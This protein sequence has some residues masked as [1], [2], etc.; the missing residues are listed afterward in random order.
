MP[1]TSYESPFMVQRFLF[2]IAASLLLVVVTGC[3]ENGAAGDANAKRP[4]KIIATTGMVADLVK[5]VVGDCGEVVSLMGPGV[6]PHLFKPLLQH[7]RKM[8]DADVIFYSGLMLEGRMQD[9][10]AQANTP[11]RPAIAVTQK[12]EQLDKDFLRS[13]PEFQGHYDPHV[14]MDVK[15]WARCMDQIV[16][17]LS[18]VDPKNA[19]TFRENA[20]NY[21][22]ELTTLDDYVRK[23]IESIPRP[24]RVLVT[25]HDAFGYFGRAYGIDVRSVQGV[26]TESEAGVRDINRLVEF[27]VQSKIPSIFVESSVSEKNLRAVIEGAKS[28]GVEIKV[29][30][31]L[32]SDAM[33]EEGTYEGTYI[34]MIDHNA[35]KIARA[36][37]GEAPERGLHG[38]LKSELQTSF[39]SSVFDDIAMLRLIALVVA[40]GSVGLCHW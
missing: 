1:S 6:D 9:A 7:V 11:K 21:A 38:R 10:I 22:A 31:E 20:T 26:T 5:H 33:G 32:F 39:R 37:D 36:L 28:R 23:S 27:L 15:A 12:L 19:E 34:G 40:G 8:N 24:Q 18:A 3:S 14:W 25:A 16:E 17:T 13:P 30:A 35:T 29:G 4:L 2:M